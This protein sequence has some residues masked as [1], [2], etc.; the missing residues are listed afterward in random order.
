MR[1]FSIGFNMLLPA[2]LAALLFIPFA[3]NSLVH[4]LYGE[5]QFPPTIMMKLPVESTAVTLPAEVMQFTPFDI[6]L[7][8]DTEAL[9]KRLNDIIAQSPHGMAMQG[10]TG[11]VHT[12][13][14]AE[15]VGSGFH[16]DNPGPQVQLFAG[17]SGTL[18]SWNVTPKAPN[19]HALTIRLHLITLDSG[20]ERQKIVDIA[21]IQT[22]VQKNPVEWMKRYGIWFVIAGILAIGI[23]WKMRRSRN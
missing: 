14:Q 11:R 21:E 7:Q 2:L 20:Q 12:N 23:W 4:Y 6:M 19:R 17:H 9:A 15:I 16:I 8:L 10:I 5:K 13:M 18:W 22:Y 3:I 1:K